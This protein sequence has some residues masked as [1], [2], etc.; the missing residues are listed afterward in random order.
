LIERLIEKASSDSIFNAHEILTDPTGYKKDSKHLTYPLK[1]WRVLYRDNKED[2]GTILKSTFRKDRIVQ[3]SDNETVI[4]VAHEEIGPR[5]LLGVLESE[6]LTSVKIVIGNWVER[7]EELYG[8][9]KETISLLELGNLLMSRDQVIEYDVF[10]I[11]LL[12]K[13][14]QH[15]RDILDQYLKP[16]GDVELEQTALIF[17]SNNL[18]ITETANKLFI[19]RNT[20]IYRLNKLESITGYDIRKFNDAMNFYLSYLVGRIN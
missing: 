17:L 11:P 9:Y 3:I 19:H 6:A 14:L 12:I 16:V 10:R 4:F 20:L 7:A 18:N 1:L 2:V 15:S 13:Q 8:S 5:D